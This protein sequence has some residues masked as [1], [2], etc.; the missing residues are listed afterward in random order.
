MEPRPTR[1]GLTLNSWWPGGSK[2]EGLA[3]L[4]RA[5][6]TLLGTRTVP[7][8]RMAIDLGTVESFG[9]SEID[10]ESQNPHIDF[11]PLFSDHAYLVCE[12]RKFW[13]T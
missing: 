3:E 11:E 2:D 10:Y 4:L 13:A 5:E 6:F 12:F 9:D 7:I 8:A 1:S